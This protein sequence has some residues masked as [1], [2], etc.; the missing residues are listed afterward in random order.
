MS[1]DFE[2]FLLTLFNTYFTLIVAAAA[3]Y[4]VYSP[5]AESWLGKQEVVQ[6]TWQDKGK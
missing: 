6:V 1:K 4:N 5:I 3:W 2:L